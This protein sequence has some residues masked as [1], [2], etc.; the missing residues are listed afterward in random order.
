[1]N[2]Q[3]LRTYSTLQPKQNDQEDTGAYMNAS[4]FNSIAVS[5]AVLTFLWYWH[6]IF[7]VICI[8]SALSSY[9][10]YKRQQ[11]SYLLWSQ[12][13]AFVSLYV[14][15]SSI[16]FLIL[17]DHGV[18]VEGS[19][20]LLPFILLMLL[21]SFWSLRGDGKDFRAQIIR[22]IRPY[23]PFGEMI[24]N[25]QAYYQEYQHLLQQKDYGITGFWMLVLY[26]VFVSIFM[27]YFDVHILDLSSDGGALS[28]LLASLFY[29]L[30]S[31]RMVVF[32]WSLL[33][34]FY[35]EKEVTMYFNERKKS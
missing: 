2:I 24:F 16:P 31:L 30:L 20:I 19:W 4:T 18:L 17:H 21:A 11:L 9:F 33:S 3:K 7:Y 23:G 35:Y 5:V 6:P 8:L 14:C 32:L 25:D 10:F 34:V 28:L 22:S 12:I 29:F 27:S 15:C 13:F 26:G 1:M